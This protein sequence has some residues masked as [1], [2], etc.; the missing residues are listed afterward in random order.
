MPPVRTD[1]VV[2]IACGDI[3]LSLKPP[4]ARAGE[5]DWLE[6]QAR[7]L[8]ELKELQRKH[9]APILCAGDIFDRWNS[10]AELINW[11]FWHLPHLYAIPGQHDLPLHRLDLIE[12]SAY[13][14]LIRG[15]IIINIQP[16][17]AVETDCTIVRAF[18]WG[19][20]LTPPHK[21]DYSKT[22]VKIAL[23][24]Q[25][26]WAKGSS[27]PGAPEEAYITHLQH[28]DGWD[29]IVAGDNHKGFLAQSYV[30]DHPH[31]FNCGTLMRR[32]SDEINY[33]PQVGLIYSDGHVEP[34]YLDTSA[35][36]ITET[37][38]AREVGE[39]MELREVL[40]E[41]SKLQ[42]NRLDFPE[43]MRHVLEE[44]NPSPAVRTLILEAMGA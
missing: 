16:R 12:K 19:I 24:H 36:I 7:P 4:I 39:D 41:L 3:H 9:N 31:I 14:T 26:I 28:T 8:T 30:G 34:H 1:K 42:D 5:P 23:I 21:E 15:D 10:T 32:K 11:A 35:D 40:E 22:R 38:A 43:A 33:K 37:A 13:K 2:A 17:E 44:R 6:A 27:Y 25:Y 18:P 20:P 29:V